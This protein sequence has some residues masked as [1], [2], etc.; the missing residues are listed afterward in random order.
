MGKGDQKSRR[1]KITN[2]SYGKRRPKKSNVAKV[3]T[4]V[5]ADK[6][7]KVKATK[8]KAEKKVEK[9]ETKVAEAK[10]KTTRKKKTEE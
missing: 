4:T 1:G 8:P 2:G 10:P 5:N 3:V 6:E 7:T 9:E